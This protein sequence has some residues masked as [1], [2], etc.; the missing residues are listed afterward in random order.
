MGWWDAHNMS[1]K[2]KKEATKKKRM[3]LWL[4]RKSEGQVDDCTLD[5]RPSHDIVEAKPL[6]KPSYQYKLNIQDTFLSFDNYMQPKG[7]AEVYDARGVLSPGP[8]SIICQ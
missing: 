7:E 3:P 1:Q 8:A 4:G 5:N 2:K 6:L